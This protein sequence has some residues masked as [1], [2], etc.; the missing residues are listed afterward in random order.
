[1][2]TEQDP[3]RDP[4]EV[5]RH[6]AHLVGQIY[7]LIEHNRRLEEQLDRLSRVTEIAELFRQRKISRDTFELPPPQGRQSP[8]AEAAWLE[9]RRLLLTLP[10]DHEILAPLQEA[11]G[12]IRA[13]GW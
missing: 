1:M 7:H 8:A 5:R 6:E 3:A 13:Q 4:D 2:A 11:L 10:E 9:V 12:M